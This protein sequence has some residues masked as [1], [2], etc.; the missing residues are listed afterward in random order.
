MNAH[1]LIEGHQLIVETFGEW[2]SFH[3]AEVRQ[4]AMTVFGDK[5]IDPVVELV[6]HG[7]KMTNEITSTG[8]YKLLNPSLI[9]L[10]FEGVSDLDVDGLNHQNVIERLVITATENSAEASLQIELEHCYGLSGKFSARK[11][12]VLSVRPQPTRDQ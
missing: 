6:I 3:D 4:L 9:H 7:W 8:H 5:K 12:K 2:P 1:E 11:A 10:R